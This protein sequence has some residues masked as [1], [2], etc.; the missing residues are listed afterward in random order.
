M[1]SELVVVGASG[2]TALP[3]MLLGSTAAE[4]AHH[5]EQPV[6]VVREA[7]SGPVV[8][9]VDGSSTSARAIGFAFDFADRHGAELVAVHAWAD[10]PIDALELYARPGR[11][12]LAFPTDDRLTC[13]AVGWRRDEF[14]R[15]RRDV[16]RQLMAEIDRLPA[17][18]E[19]VRAAR[20]VER[21]R[22]TGD[23][24]TFLRKPHGPGW[25]L[26]GDAGYY[27]DPITGQGI[28]DALRSAELFAEAWAEVRRGA[29]WTA[30]MAGYQERRDAETA[31]MYEFTDML[32]RFDPLTEEGLGLF[33]AIA[34]DPNLAFEYAGIFN[35]VTNP[36]E[37][38]ARFRPPARAEANGGS[39][40]AT[41]PHQRNGQGPAAR[42][43]ARSA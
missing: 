28:Y 34:A 17:L 12:V 42:P 41:A 10:L 2:K 35:G 16:E 23:L 31:A 20:R 7:V 25:A 18:A 33:R 21:F 15:V 39:E 38:L 1:A 13:V 14:G 19:R 5:C 9:G 26:I 4:L 27:K 3:R 37:F 22:G 24:P 43:V 32:A 29:D 11:Y 6:V 40:R 36:A 8:V 30:A